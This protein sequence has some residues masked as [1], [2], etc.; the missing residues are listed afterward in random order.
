M[1]NDAQSKYDVLLVPK[2]DQVFSPPPFPYPFLFY[3][4]FFASKYKPIHPYSFSIEPPY[5]LRTTDKQP[6]SSL[7]PLIYQLFE[8][9]YEGWVSGC[10]AVIN[11]DACAVNMMEKKKVLSSKC[12]KNI[13]YF[14]FYYFL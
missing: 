1:E 9:V 5:F 13:C 3:V 7:S 10:R 6:M 4:L 14:I 2:W 12:K 11:G 8:L